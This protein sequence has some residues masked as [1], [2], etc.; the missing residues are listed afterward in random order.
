[1]AIAIRVIPVTTAENVSES[2]EGNKP[3]MTSENIE[4][5]NANPILSFRPIIYFIFPIIQLT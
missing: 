2:T 4:I 3:A 1:M 5:T